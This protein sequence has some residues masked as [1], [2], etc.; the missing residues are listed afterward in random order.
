[1]SKLAI[2]VTL[3]ATLSVA[4]AS[5]S[6][7][8]PDD[9]VFLSDVDPSILQDMRY[10]TQNNFTGSRVPGYNSGQCVLLRPAAEALKQVQTELQR[11][12]LSLKVYDCYRPVRAVHAFMRWTKRQANSGKSLLAYIAA[13]SIHSTGIAVDLTLVALPVTPSASFDPRTTYGACN[14]PK[15]L[16]SPD[17]SVDIGTG[18]DCFDPMSNTSSGK[19]TPEQEANRHMLLTAMTAAGFQNYPGEW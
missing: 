5:A 13:R 10:A 16:R 6:V 12:K 19:I 7:H 14:G 4:T 9:F 11:N 2:A 18:F 8:L 15:E 17:D 1:V 3:L